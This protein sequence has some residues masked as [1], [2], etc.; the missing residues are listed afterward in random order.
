MA[1]I[2]FGKLKSDANES[3]RRITDPR[4]LFNSL[5]G[6]ASKFDY[7]RGP[8]DQVLDAWH[9]RRSEKDLVIKMNTGGGKSTVG[10]LAA[11]S[12]LNEDVGPVA[13]LVPN[14]HLAEQVRAEAN[15]LGI[16]VTNE[17]RSPEYARGR[18]ILVDVFSR[19]VNGKS[20]FGIQGAIS[21]PASVN[22]GALVIDDAHACIAQAEQAFR[23]RVDETNPAYDAILNLFEEELRQQSTNSF[24][25]LK[26]GRREAL[27]QIPHW[28]WFDKH[29]DVMDI[30][31]P[32]S[33]D[34]TL[35]F[36]WP[37]VVDDISNST[38]VITSKAIE[39]QPAVL[40]I[41]KIIGFANAQRR[42][43]LTATL[44]D[45]SILVRDFSAKEASISTPIAPTGA[46]DIGDRLILLPQQIFPAASDEDVR[47]FVTALSEDQNV[48]VIVPSRHR[49][50]WWWDDATLILDKDNIQEGVQ[51]L[52]ENP[53][54]G[55]VVLVNRYD[56]IDLP[57]N[58]C[59][60]LVIDGLPEPL[61]GVERLEQAQLTSSMKLM[62]QQIQ[63]LEQGMGRATRS[64]EDYSAVLLLGQK[65]ANRLNSPNA[66]DFFS[67]ATQ[68][69]MEL[70]EAMADAIHA[71]DIYDLREVV[72]QCLE[73]D[74]DW[75]A[76]NKGVLAELRYSP[77]PIPPDAIAERK[78]FDAAGR[79]DFA[80]SRKLIQSLVDR[81]QDASRRA[82][83]LQQLSAYT[84]PIDPAEAQ[85][86][87]ASA[88]RS[89][90]S[91]LR[92]R[93]GVVYRP[94]S[95][96]ATDQGEAASKFLSETYRDGNDL[97]NGFES[98]LTDLQWGASF[99]RFETAVNDLARHIGIAGHMPDQETGIGP[100]GLWMLTDG[101]YL[102][103]E[104]KN[105]VEQDRAV[106]KTEAGQ[107]SQSMD[108]FREHYMNALAT[109]VLI[110]P[111]KKFERNAA[112]PTGCRVVNMKQL[113]KLRTSLTLLATRLAESN[114][115]TSPRNVAALLEQRSLLGGS[116]LESYTEAGRSE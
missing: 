73:R 27:Q 10:L 21:K 46:G 33:D 83:L 26:S 61:S 4:D 98:I 78:A 65:I 102:V 71:D 75:I 96:T 69:Q 59:H 49:A 32:I 51:Q 48:V 3:S 89:N 29:S 20:I 11:R 68:A 72:Q 25:D 93:S 31:H 35:K 43:Y 42:V 115:F 24:L 2:N 116:F 7:L 39:I 60:V 18:A 44:A 80:S 50:E 101:N 30:L 110:H 57:G 52:R 85:A 58:S 104:S 66:R 15:S 106:Y 107:L 13:Y 37:L 113:R 17:P 74:P 70:A 34:D 111:S 84:H 36:A 81:E 47:K 99:T 103:I 95:R 9:K 55:L 86:I 108:W 1:K 53:K 79:G 6:K 88:N 109:P 90:I 28:A 77:T 41:N 54:T 14:K 97:I 8:Q 112:I 105:E 22:L 82:V 114:S 56:G 94:I 5:P 45:D 64:N 100:D 16:E 63:R 67:P 92:P 62:R 38:A 91:L 23:L 87:Q 12:L 19:L 76:L 40:P